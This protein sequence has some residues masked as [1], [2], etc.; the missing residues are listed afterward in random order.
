MLVGARQDVGETYF[1][2]CTKVQDIHDNSLVRNL[3]N[4][5]EDTTVQDICDAAMLTAIKR[6]LKKDRTTE[7]NRT[8]KID[9]TSS[10]GQ[11][12]IVREEKMH[13]TK[14][15]KEDHPKLHLWLAS[16]FQLL[17]NAEILAVESANGT[18]YA[19]IKG[20]V[21]HNL[22]PESQYH[23]A[24]TIANL[25]EY[26]RQLIVNNIA[27]A[28]ETYLERK[29]KEYEKSNGSVDTYEGLL[30]QYT[31]ATLKCFLRAQKRPYSKNILS[32][33]E[34]EDNQEFSPRNFLNF[35]LLWKI[36]T[37]KIADAVLKHIRELRNSS[38][39]ITP[40]HED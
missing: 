17:S 32:E 3:V 24:N 34:Q 29:K 35:I 2:N 20:K 10:K 38:L 31:V 23:S 5:S 14:K 22:A 19:T 18:N 25:Q 13:L 4:L 27:P 39:E 30:D 16:H 21:V 6:K 7:Q 37:D 28:Y 12:E 15:A 11:G 33:Y 1:T 9:S 26:G 8:G 36:D 40:A